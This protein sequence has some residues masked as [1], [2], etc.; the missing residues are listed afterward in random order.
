M[1]IAIIVNR[2]FSAIAFCEEISWIGDRF[3]IC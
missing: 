1:A 2:D 3:L